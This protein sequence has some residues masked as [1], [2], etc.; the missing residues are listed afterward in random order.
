MQL[1]LFLPDPGSEKPVL[2]IRKPDIR[3][4]KPEKVDPKIRMRKVI[5]D[6]IPENAIEQVITWLLDQKVQLKISNSRSTKLG[7][8]RPAWPGKIPVITVNHNLNIYAFLVTL[9]HEMAHHLVMKEASHKQLNPFRK[10]HHPRPH[11]LE[12][13]EQYRKLMDPYL[14]PG[15]L[16]V[17]L[18]EAVRQYLANPRASTTAD[19]DLYRILRQ[20][21]DPDGSEFIEILPFDALFHLRNGRRFIKKEK[22]RKR[23]RCVSVENG[24]IYLFNP[25]AQ[26]FR[27]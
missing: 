16:P 23:Y 10:K 2:K 7:D 8:Y 25:M 20:Y 9:V 13:Q 22:I 11:G 21:D 6:F 4:E 24:K 5:S 15:I 26:V 18:V 14:V 27:I 12:W 19:K 17:D 1:S 3:V